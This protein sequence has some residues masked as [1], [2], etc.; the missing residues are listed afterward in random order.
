MRLARLAKN[1]INKIMI[2]YDYCSVAPNNSL[3]RTAD[4]T[5]FTLFF[6]FQVVHNRR[7]RS[8]VA[9]VGRLPVSNIGNA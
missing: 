3:D 5:L 6:A 7:A 1:S 2:T 8:T 4:G 9:T